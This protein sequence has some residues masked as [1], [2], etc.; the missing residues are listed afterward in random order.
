MLTG[1]KAS[2][3]CTALLASGW[4]ASSSVGGKK[5]PLATPSP[6]GAKP[7]PPPKTTS[8]SWRN[9][10]TRS[11]TSACCA[12]EASAPIFTPS[13]DGSPTTT[14]A[15]RAAMRSATASRCWRGTMARRMAVHFW[16]ALMVISRTTSLTNRSNS[17][18]SG[19]TSGARM[20]AF[21]ES[22]SALNGMLWRTTFGCTR[23]LAAVSAEPVKVTTS[24]PSR[25]SSRSPVEPI[26]SCSA[27]AGRMPD[28]L[29][30]RTMASVR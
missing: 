17:S 9:S 16:P 25:R 29:T 26:T 27:P 20:A 21:S 12:C 3:S 23:S 10:A 5:A 2:T 11:A 24:R 14:L 13:T 4:R 7:S 19:V 18:S 8:A 30:M 22:A 1:P 28:S 15:R 6:N